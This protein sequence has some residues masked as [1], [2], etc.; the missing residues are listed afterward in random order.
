M[1]KKEHITAFYL[2]TLL[3]IAV[4]ISIILVLTRVFGSARAQSARAKH[5]TEAVTLA[6]NTAEAVS[7]SGSAKELRALLD[8]GGNA[9]LQEKGG[10]AFAVVAA[11]D[12]S[13]NPVPLAQGQ[14]VLLQGQASSPQERGGEEMTGADRE[15]AAPRLLQAG[16]LLVKATW[17]PETGGAGAAEG[18]DPAGPSEGTPEMID[19]S[20][21]T[22]AAGEGDPAG[23]SEGTAEMID[24]SGGAEEAGGAGMVHSAITVY[25]G[26]TGSEIYSIRTAV[27]VRE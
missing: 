9:V 5:L 25:D 4:F 11:Y 3:M 15:S 17:E 22:G 21:G 18:G 16:A 23:P 20:G 6:Q 14:E 1:N 2:E 27:Y 12:L 19:L 7:A 24:L 26:G 13:M 10:G 8:Q